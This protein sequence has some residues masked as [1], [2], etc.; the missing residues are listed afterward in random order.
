[1]FLHVPKREAK[2]QRCKGA[3]YARGQRASQRPDCDS[4]QRGL[5]DTPAWELGLAGVPCVTWELVR[6]SNVEWGLCLWLLGE[7]EEE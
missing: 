3:V 1:M 7:K 5:T 4:I 6:V 2:Q